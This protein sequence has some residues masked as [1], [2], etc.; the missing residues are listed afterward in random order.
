MPNDSD[1]VISKQ[2]FYSLARFPGIIGA[3][4]GSHVPIIAPKE[5][6]HLFVNRKNFHSINVQVCAFY[7]A[8]CLKTL[9]YCDGFMFNFSSP[10]T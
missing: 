4:D 6:E 5:D 2:Q 3:I 9:K 1:A 8:I 10:H 7:N